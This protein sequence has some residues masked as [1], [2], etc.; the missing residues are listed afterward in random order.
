MRVVNIYSPG[1]TGEGTMVK[2]F[3]KMADKKTTG[4]GGIA[5]KLGNLTDS[6]LA[7][8]VKESA[9]QIWLAGMGAFSKTQEE[10]QK[11]FDVLVKEG[12]GLQKKTQRFAED[13]VTDVTSK[14]NKAAG[15]LSKQA[16]HTWDKLETVFE[17]RVARALNRLGVP[18]KREIEALLAKVEELNKSVHKLSG[19]RPAA[20]RPVAAAKKA[21]KK[22]AK[23][24][25][26]TVKAAKSAAK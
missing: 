12:M 25:A 5:D 16:N 2:K 26:K 18:T 6:Q 7:A 8:A 13:K 20:A 4:L 10:G 17:D 22:T 15:D 9:Q 24:A 23:K 19:T 11:V 1:G 21:V 14:M 3:K